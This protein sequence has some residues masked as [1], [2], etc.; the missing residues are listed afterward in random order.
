MNAINAATAATMASGI[1][2]SGALDKENSSLGMP[3]STE[4]V[5]SFTVVVAVTPAKQKRTT[6]A[7]ARNAAILERVIPTPLFLKR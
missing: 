1:S 2:S 5:T 7:S 4:T 3:I 6:N